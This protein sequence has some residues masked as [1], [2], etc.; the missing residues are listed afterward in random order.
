M[1]ARNAVLLAVVVAVAG[2]LRANGP[3]D[4]MDKLQGE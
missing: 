2:G 4:D 1:S 3:K